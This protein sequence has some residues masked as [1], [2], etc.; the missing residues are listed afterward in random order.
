MGEQLIGFVQRACG[1]ALTGDVS[2]QYLFIPYGAGRNGKSTLFNTLRRLLGSY[3]VQLAPELLLA[4]RNEQHPTG[5]TDLRGARFAV[6]IEIDQGRQ[7][8]EALAKMLTGGENIRARR[9]RQDFFEFS[10]THKLW[11]V[12]N[13]L[14]LIR[15]ADLGIWRRILVVP[16]AVTI[17]PG[18][19][20]R[21]LSE[22]LWVERDGILNWQVQ[23]CLA[24]QRDGLAP[25]DAVRIATAKYRQEQDH[26][27]AFL[28]AACELGDGLSAN[29]QVLRQRYENWCDDSG[30]EALGKT[31]FGRLLTE[32]GFPTSLDRRKR[33]GIALCQASHVQVVQ[34]LP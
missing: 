21:N 27:A 1:V 15:G 3:A 16:F 2:E 19:E 34:V 22:K 5:L 25:P 18:Q 10:P 26:L 23:G 33:L 14:P 9:M 11:L 31:M 20:D 6:T 8:A 28:A 7:M 24:W 12:V 29:A 32:R 30:E 13:H 4:T 17:D